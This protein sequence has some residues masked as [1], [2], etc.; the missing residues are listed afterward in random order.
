MNQ[1]L[2][3]GRTDNKDK[4]KRK[5]ETRS[6]EYL[7]FPTTFFY[8]IVKSRNKKRKDQEKRK[9]SKLKIKRINSF[10]QGKVKKDV[11]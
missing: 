6:K 11:A 9:K 3:N 2:R 8:N 7:F 4:E 5:N 1:I 10:T